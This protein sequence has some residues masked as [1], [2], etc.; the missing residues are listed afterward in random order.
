MNIW[1]R[2]LR[3]SGITEG[4]AANASIDDAAKVAGHSGKRTTATVYDRAVLE[5]AGC[6]ADARILGREQSGN[7]GGNVR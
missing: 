7:G 4:R 1:A 6:F 5:A 2:D 3:A